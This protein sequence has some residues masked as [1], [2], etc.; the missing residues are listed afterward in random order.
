MGDNGL[1][2]IESSWTWG[3]GFGTVVGKIGIITSMDEDVSCFELG[4]SLVTIIL[5]KENES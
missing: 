2:E 3:G 1:V 5:A 4:R